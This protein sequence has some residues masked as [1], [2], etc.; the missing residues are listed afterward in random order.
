MAATIAFYKTTNNLGGAITASTT[1]GS[2]I[3][4]AFTGDETTT[5][6][7]EYA[8]VYVKNTGDATAFN[9][10]VNIE[11]ETSHAGA[12][13]QIGL[14]SAAVNGSEQTV[15]DK[16]T[17]PGSV[18]FAEAASLAAAL[19]V[20]DIP[21]GQHKAVWVKFDISAGTL[22]KNS[23]SAPVQATFDTGE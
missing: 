15:A 9:V 16:N 10:R 19:T 5:G 6:T 7:T 8:C 18:T 20:G 13:A 17:A 3:F 21:A 14:G 22:A 2:D 23:Y 1:D 12:N 11:G 4:D